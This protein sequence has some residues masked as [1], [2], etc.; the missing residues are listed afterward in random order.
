ML[1]SE[2]NTPDNSEVREIRINPIVP[3]ESVLVATARSMRPKKAEELAPRDTRKHVE[4]CPFCSGNEH[5]TP[6]AILTWPETGDWHIRMVENLYPVLGDDRSQS[7]FTFGLQQTIDGYGRHE[8]IIDHNEHGIA[9]HD[10]A[11]SHLAALFGVYQTRMRQL[12][13]S[14][15]RLKYVLVFKNFGPAAG[16]SIPHTHSQVIAMPVVP[17]NVDAEVKNSAAHYAKHHHCIFCALIDEALTFE[18][19][20]YDRNSG[21]V[22]RKINVGQYVVERG[23]KFI[24]IKPFAS[25]YEWEVHILP[26]AHQADFLDVR[27]EDMADLARVMKRTMARLDAVIGGAQYNFFLHSVPHSGPDSK[28]GV[29]HDRA[30]G[31][32]A[33]SYHWHLEICPRTSIPTGFE[34]GSGLFVNTI[35][36]EQAAERLR[37]VEL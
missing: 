20:I 11:E 19:T 18:A 30:R 6:P 4:T 33:A 10:M 21:A 14:D 3:S 25:R 31:E 7:G 34:L 26:L 37:A 1:M 13:E 36:P 9:V 8:V 23:E 27:S 15:D 24:A 29:P 2:Q 17:E 12:F 16:A 35:N 5:K 22:R 32:Y 28:H